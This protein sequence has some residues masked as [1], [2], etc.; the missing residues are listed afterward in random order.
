MDREPTSRRSAATRRTLMR[1]TAW[2]V[3]VVLTTVAAPSFAASAV[4]LTITATK[5]SPGN[6]LRLTFTGGTGNVSVTNV[7]RN[8]STIALS[9]PTPTVSADGGTADGG[10]TSYKK[11]DSYQ[12]TY[13]YNSGTY[14]QTIAGT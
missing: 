10:S 11:G 5:A 7:L 4:P 6:T 1:T 8:G 2:A 9:P 3:P 13:V 12:V 14:N